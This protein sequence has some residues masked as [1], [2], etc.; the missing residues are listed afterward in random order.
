[1]SGGLKVPELAK[2]ALS[3]GLS[4]RDQIA[5]M[6]Q[7]ASEGREAEHSSNVGAPR[8]MSNRRCSSHAPV[9]RIGESAAGLRFRPCLPQANKLALALPDSS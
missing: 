1:M 4:A 7:A 2:A 3:S 6:A 9:F 8:Q 5:R